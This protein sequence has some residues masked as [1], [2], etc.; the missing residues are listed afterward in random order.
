[1]TPDTNRADGTSACTAED[2]EEVHEF[3]TKAHGGTYALDTSRFSWLFGGSAP[4]SD[5]S[6]GA[7]SFWITR[8]GG[9]IVGTIG[10]IPFHLKVGD[11]TLRAAWGVEFMI[12]PEWR[13]TAVGEEITAERK[14]HLQVSCGLGM[15]EAGHRAASRR[16]SVD[17]GGMP[18]YTALLTPDAVI[19][20]LRPHARLA[21]AARPLAAIAAWL[22]GALCRLRSTGSR[23]ASISEFDERADHL[24]RQASPAYPVLARRDAAWLR[25]RFDQCPDRRLYQRYYLTRRG[26]LA[27]YVVTRDTT[28]SERPALTVVDYFAAPRDLGALFATVV[29]SARR[30]GAGVVLCQTLIPRRAFSLRWVGLVRRRARTRS[31][32]W[33][34]EGEP[35]ASLVSDPS[36]W[37]LTAA[38][39]DVD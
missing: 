33:T 26:R 11:R 14:R 28:W 36:N 8:R 3:Q 19:D 17:M 9:R 7:F 34:A 23:L 29:T 35:L 30:R 24:W 10:S 4:G 38:D 2:L 20:L 18:L 12:L 5:A 13:G 32:V 1:M 6:D 27:G 25:W 31:T 37:F 16:S 15:S 39:S 21:R 22:V